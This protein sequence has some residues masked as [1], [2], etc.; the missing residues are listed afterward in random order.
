M[1]LTGFTTAAIGAGLAVS[2]CATVPPPAPGLVDADFAS[3]GAIADQFQQRLSLQLITALR[4]GGPVAGIEVCAR[5]APAIAATLSQ[6]TGSEVRRIS[7]APRNPAAMPQAHLAA[8]L[9]DLQAS[10]LDEEGRPRMIGWIE[11]RGM[12]A[13]QITLRSVVMQDQPCGACHGSEIAPDVQ[14]AIDRHYPA[15]TA[16]GFSAGELRGAIMV[17]RRV[18]D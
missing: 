13:R 6:E 8:P 16:T 12:D 4:E 11:G 14:A 18:Q 9:R 3:A 7:L 5:E 2:S 1:K 15:D 17:S 10:P